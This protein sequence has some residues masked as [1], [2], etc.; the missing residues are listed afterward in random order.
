MLKPINIGFII[1]INENHLGNVLIYN[2]LREFL[3][4][5]KYILVTDR[6]SIGSPKPRSI[7]V[8]R[9]A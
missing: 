1:A 2:Y 5:N 4:F 8:G 3:V 9:G 6:E 7:P